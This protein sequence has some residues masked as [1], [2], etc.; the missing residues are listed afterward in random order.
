MTLFIKIKQYIIWRLIEV[1]KLQML[2]RVDQKFSRIA[3]EL[4]EPYD[5]NLM[6]KWKNIQDYYNYLIDLKNPFKKEIPKF[7]WNKFTYERFQAELI[8][9]GIKTTIKS[10]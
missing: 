7:P 9:T 3:V 1:P 6:Q 5:G 10:K 4:G 8:K 2:C